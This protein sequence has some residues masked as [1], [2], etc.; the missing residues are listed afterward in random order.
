MKT[1]P[2]GTTKYLLINHRNVIRNAE[3]HGVQA[4]VA[5]VV[6]QLDEKTFRHH[7]AAS[8]VARGVVRLEYSQHRPLPLGRHILDHVAF[9]TTDEVDLLGVEAPAVAPAAAPV[10]ATKAPKTPKTA[11]A[12]A[13]KE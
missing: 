5:E 8:V 13:P 3:R 11:P 6:E 9:V 1:L 7:I 4:P 2:K 12:T 10:P